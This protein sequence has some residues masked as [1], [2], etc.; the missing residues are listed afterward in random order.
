[1]RNGVLEVWSIGG[2]QWGDGAKENFQFEQLST[3]SA[4]DCR[5]SFRDRGCQVFFDRPF[6]VQRA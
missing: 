3:G 1:M 2:M 6:R 5:E 4:P